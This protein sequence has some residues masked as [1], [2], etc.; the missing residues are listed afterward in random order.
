MTVT[1]VPLFTFDASCACSTLGTWRTA[2]AE[3]LMRCRTLQASM[4]VSPLVPSSAKGIAIRVFSALPWAPR[5]G[6]CVGF[7]A[8]YPDAEVEQCLDR[9]GPCARAIVGDGDR[10]VRRGRDDHLDGRRNA[11]LF[12]GIE[13]VVDKLFEHDQWP[14]LD[15]MSRLQHQFLL[16]A[17]LEHSAGCENRASELGCGGHG[18]G[19]RD[20]RATSVR[21]PSALTISRHFRRPTISISITACGPTTWDTGS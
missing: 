10:G 8:G 21:T 6:L 1:E 14:L 20:S 16:R 5:V 11:G 2:S 3:N 9:F 17:K 13:R 7:A 19:S 15:R 18:K 4:M 12:A